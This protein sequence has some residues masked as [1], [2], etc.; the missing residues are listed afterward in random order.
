MRAPRVAATSGCESDDNI[1]VTIV[2][3]VPISTYHG[4]AM[5]ASGASV[6]A[7]NGNAA[8]SG[9]AD[10]TIAIARIPTLM[11]ISAS[12]WIARRQKIPRKKPPSNPPYVKLAIDNASTT[13]GVPCA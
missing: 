13:T 6:G 9:F 12:R 5:R 8:P 1:P 3:E 4:H 2:I 11:P 7:R 10:T